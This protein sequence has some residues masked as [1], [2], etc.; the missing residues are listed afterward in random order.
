MLVSV[1]LVD[2]WMCCVLYAVLFVCSLSALYTQYDAV[3]FAS[4]EWC[5]CF[6][7]CIQTRLLIVPHG[8]IMSQRGRTKTRC[9]ALACPASFVLCVCLACV[10]P[11][12]FVASVPVLRL[13]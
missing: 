9:A 1:L 6:Q 7:P 10:S 8:H 13:Y 4:C 2:V 12:S 3:C 11:V 5:V